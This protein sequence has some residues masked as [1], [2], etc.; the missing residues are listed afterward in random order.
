MQEILELQ[1]NSPT[2]QMGESFL[3]DEGCAV[4]GKFLEEHDTFS[5]ID[6]HGNNISGTGITYLCK[7]LSVS[8][9]LKEYLL[10][11]S[12]HT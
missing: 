2:L 9:T 8:E 7:Y 5:K 6:L 4:V 11:F 1:K 12:K 10:L 3:G